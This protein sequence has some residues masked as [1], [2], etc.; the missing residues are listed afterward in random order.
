MSRTEALSAKFLY[1]REHMYNQ[2]YIGPVPHALC[3]YKQITCINPAVKMVFNKNTRFTFG[4][5]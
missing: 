3:C 4:L 1:D 2:D 5:K